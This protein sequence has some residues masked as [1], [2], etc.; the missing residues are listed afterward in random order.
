MSV[1]NEYEEVRLLRYTGV[2]EKI[3]NEHLLC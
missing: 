1:S 3:R 2:F